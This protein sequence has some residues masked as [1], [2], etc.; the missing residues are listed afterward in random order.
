MSCVLPLRQT[1]ARAFSAAIEQRGSHS[2]FKSVGKAGQAGGVARP[3]SAFSTSIWKRVACWL[4]ISGIDGHAGPLFGR[5]APSSQ[6]LTRSSSA[7]SESIAENL[8]IGYPNI[9]G[10]F[11]DLYRVTPVE[12]MH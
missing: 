3:T 10:E 11:V 7:C 12:Q 5:L 8:T 6:R 9:V 1:A 4:R 2:R